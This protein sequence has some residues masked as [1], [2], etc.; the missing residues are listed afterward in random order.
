MMPFQFRCGS[1]H[2]RGQ[3][4]DPASKLN[5][6]DYVEVDPV[7]KRLTVHF[8]HY[9][10]GTAPKAGIA[11]AVANVAIDG[12]ERIHPVV[13]AVTTKPSALELDVTVDQL[14]DFSTYTLRLRASDVSIETP[15]GFDPPLSRVD[16]SFRLD[17]D[18]GLD[19][20]TPTVC[21]PTAYDEPEVDYEARDYASFRRLMLDRLSAVTPAWTDR[22]PADF[23]VAMV[24][25]F[26]YLGDQLTYAQDAVATDAYLATA[27]RR[28]SV[29][30]HARLLDYR[31]HDGCNARA[32][33]HF[34]VVAGGP[35]VLLPTGSLLLS[36]GP[37]GAVVDPTK[38]DVEALLLREQPVVFETMQRATLRATQNTI[39]FYTWGDFNCCLPAGATST[40]LRE[41]NPLH[42]APGDVLIFEEVLSPSDGAEAGAAPWRRHPVRLTRSDSRVDLEAGVNIVEIGWGRADALPF[43]FCLSVTLEGRAIE[44]VSVARGNV[45]LADAGR[46]LRPGPLTATSPPAVGRFR[47]RLGRGPL[48]FAAPG[49][50]LTQPPS[51][52]PAAAATRWDVRGAV[53][54]MALTDGHRD[55]HARPD[56]L[57][58]GR[59]ATEYVVETDDDG[60]ATLRFGDGTHGLEPDPDLIFNAAYRVG[61][62]TSGNLPRGTISR[63]VIVGGGIDL[64]RN[65]L[66]AVGGSDPE[67]TERVKLIAP[68][69]VRT[70]LRAVTEDDYAEVTQRRPD[71]HKAAAVFRWTGSWYTSF[72]TVEPHGAIGLDT[73]QKA[74]LEEYLGIY[75]MAGW[76]VEVEPPVP[77]S[78]DI[79][80]RVCVK[81]GFLASHVKAAMIDALGTTILPDGT[82]AF[83]NPENFSFGQPLFLSAL[84]QAALA[85]HGVQSVQVTRLERLGA[86]SDVAL[87]TGDFTVG[88]FEVVRCDSDPN[89]PD[90]GRI[91]L[92]M[93][94]G[95]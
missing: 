32:W 27:R 45:V 47:P 80:L 54:A 84:Y 28:T 46:W 26:A 51:T 40:T 88:R 95:A 20:A 13:T 83:F 3:V 1:E 8:F 14:G 67:A 59:F 21:P 57:R 37:G 60:I 94:G 30:R 79:A 44:D 22:N 2:R 89:F 25:L 71:V 11:L 56:L 39:R 55:W 42:L 62:G 72:V 5:G 15:P 17:C 68:H 61:N 81:A 34:R 6:I 4:A 87:N 70:Q 48:T 66:A 50:D 19:C 63:A 35:D 18:S 10:P 82:R 9:L 74:D 16:F 69:A 93:V 38:V 52:Q 86:P 78:L 31:M 53:P 23:G 33:V 77:V 41:D 43:P 65:P 64:V 76:D 75:R 36:G 24:E 7:Q 12:G 85:V 73:T 92:E 58:S 90:R 91:T 49:P 29:R